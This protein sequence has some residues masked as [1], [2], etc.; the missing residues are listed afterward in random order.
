MSCVYIHD[1][2]RLPEYFYALFDLK[3]RLNINLCSI[4]HLASVEIHSNEHTMELFFV[5]VDIDS[6]HVILYDVRTRDERFLS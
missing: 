3:L 5:C 1:G 2:T 6:T 4:R